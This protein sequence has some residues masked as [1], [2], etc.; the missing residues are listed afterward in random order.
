ME[1]NL[2]YDEHPEMRLSMYLILQNF[3]AG[4]ALKWYEQ[5]WQEIRSSIEAYQQVAPSQKI[6]KC[7]DL[8]QEVGEEILQLE[9]DFNRLFVGPD[10]LLA[11][12]YESSYRNRDQTLMQKETLQVREFYSRA[13]LEVANK[14]VEPDDHLALELEFIGYLYANLTDDGFRRLYQEFLEKHLMVWYKEHCELIHK[15][16][17]NPICQAMAYL[18]EGVIEQ[19]QERLCYR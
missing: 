11:S 9:F 16:S 14:G 2:K 15:H 4:R 3:Y 12:P 13:G 6:M 8:L 7:L 18:L 1:A 5:D 17:E 19:E 10:K